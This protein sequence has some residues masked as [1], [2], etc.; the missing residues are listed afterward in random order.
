MI[1]HQSYKVAFYRFYSFYKSLLYI[2]FYSLL[3]I[4]HYV[5][6]METYWYINLLHQFNHFQFFIKQWY[7]YQ[8][9]YQFIFKFLQTKLQWTFLHISLKY[10]QKPLQDTRIC[11]PRSEIA[12][13][14]CTSVGDNIKKENTF[15]LLLRV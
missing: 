3:F 11:V 5:V 7:I 9:H 4:Q 10:V 15:P 2:S 13:S 8:L 6:E 14:I 12:E 1:L